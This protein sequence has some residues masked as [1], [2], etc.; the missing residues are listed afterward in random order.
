M[1]NFQW[2]THRGVIL[3]ELS[4][5]EFILGRQ[6]DVV[7]GALIEVAHHEARGLGRYLLGEEI[8]PGIV[9]RPAVLQRNACEM[10][11]HWE[12]NS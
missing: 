3:V 11:L 10:L 7:G 2:Q 5:A 4:H 8:G 9:V 12:E 6:L 1:E